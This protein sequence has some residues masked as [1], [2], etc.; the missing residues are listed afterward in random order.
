[1]AAN[2]TMP[3][4]A[5]VSAGVVPQVAIATLVVHVT[6]MAV[7]L[8]TAAHAVISAKSNRAS[9]HVAKR[10]S[11]HAKTVA[12]LTPLVVVIGLTTVLH[13][14]TPGTVATT[15]A[16]L[17]KTHDRRPPGL[18]VVGK[19]AAATTATALAPRP[20]VPQAT[21][22]RVA[23]SSLVP[24]ISSLMALPM[25]ALQVSVAAHAS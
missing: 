17:V 24:A 1:M 23:P 25:K 21:S 5:V 15:E 13:R 11:T 4:P 6:A 3:M 14:H 8:T 19:N 9:S 12:V 20:A 7:V 22:S 18:A 2:A 16:H 10:V